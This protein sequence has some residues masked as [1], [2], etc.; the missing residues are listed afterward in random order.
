MQKDIF[1]RL[2]RKLYIDKPKINIENKDMRKQFTRISVL[3]ALAMIPLGLN[4]QQVL[5]LEE[6]RD[7]AIKNNKDL[8]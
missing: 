6:C 8:I 5:S 3:A 4:A 1:L 7:M 2:K